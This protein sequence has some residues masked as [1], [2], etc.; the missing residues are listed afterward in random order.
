MRVLTVAVLLSLAVPG[1]RALAYDEV[2]FLAAEHSSGMAQFNLRTPSGKPATWLSLPGPRLTAQWTPLN[3]VFIPEGNGMVRIYIGPKGENDDIPYYFTDI[4]VNGV[5]LDIKEA[6]YS[7]IRPLGA[8]WL[9]NPPRSGEGSRAGELGVAYGSPASTQACLKVYCRQGACR[10]IAVKKGEPVEVTMLGKAG[11]VLEAYVSRLSTVTASL[12]EA[13]KASPQLRGGAMETGR[14]LVQGLNEL[15]ALSE[16]RLS[17]SVP[18]LSVNAV[19]LQSLQAKTVELARA[20][21]DEADRHG[22]TLSLHDQPPVRAELKGKITQ[23]ARLATRLKTACLVSFFL[24][25]P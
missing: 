22:E 9:M 18:L 25:V 14:Q 15:I 2:L 10:E 1:Y 17:V 12:G 23:V 7:D 16:R 20:Y 8:K 11:S 4:R 21:Q 6:C 13:S 5:P 24:G 3:F 19:S